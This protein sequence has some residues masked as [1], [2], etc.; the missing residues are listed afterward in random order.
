MAFPA[1][2]FSVDKNIEEYQMM[3]E[4]PSMGD[5]CRERC[6][7]LAYQIA[8]IGTSEDGIKKGP[9]ITYDVNNKKFQPA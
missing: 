2:H 3:S 7:W 1:D 9:W 8:Q 5:L 4:T 6:L